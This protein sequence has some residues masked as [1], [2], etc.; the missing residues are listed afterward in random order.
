MYQFIYKNKETGQKVY[1]NKELDD[2]NLELVM[3]V[4]KVIISKPI[5]TKKK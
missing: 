2:K 5:R 3:G 4:R 1:S